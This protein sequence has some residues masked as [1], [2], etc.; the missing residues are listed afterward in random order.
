MPFN[1]FSDTEEDRE[2]AR[3]E[4]Q[5]NR[6]RLAHIETELELYRHPSWSYMQGR[7]RL[8]EMKDME[9]MIGAAPEDLSNLQTRVKLVRHLLEVP[10]NLEIERAQIRSVLEESEGE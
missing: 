10:V 7:L 3:Q 9:A 4:A 8:I 1:L 2:E 5:E 6:S